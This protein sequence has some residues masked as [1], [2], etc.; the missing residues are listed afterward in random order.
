MAENESFTKRMITLWFYIF[1]MNDSI[2]MDSKFKQ[3]MD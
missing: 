2:D 1:L 3:F